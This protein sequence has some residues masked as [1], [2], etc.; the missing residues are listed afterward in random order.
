M[1]ERYSIDPFGA[2]SNLDDR[3]YP[4]PNCALP[5]TDLTASLHRRSRPCD[6]LNS[7]QDWFTEGQIPV[8]RAIKGLDSVRLVATWSSRTR[9]FIKVPY[10]DDIAVWD[11]LIHAILSNRGSTQAT[12]GAV[13]RAQQSAADHGRP[14]PAPED[15]SLTVPIDCSGQTHRVT[16]SLGGSVTCHDHDHMDSD[17]LVAAVTGTAIPCAWITGDLPAPGPGADYRTRLAYEETK[18]QYGLRALG[19]DLDAHRRWRALDADPATIDWWMNASASP[20]DADAWT[21][22]GYTPWEA[23][24]A[25]LHQQYPA[26]SGWTSFNGTAEEWR[27]AGIDVVSAHTWGGW[28]GLATRSLVDERL[29]GGMRAAAAPGFTPGAAREL[30]SRGVTYRAAVAA[31]TRW[32]EETLPPASRRI[33]VPLSLADVDRLPLDGLYA[34]S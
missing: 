12:I 22:A 21:A 11:I 3:W 32:R 26:Q 2:W 23:H 19:R 29:P 4:C 13:R 15:W 24:I 17:A 25:V 33:D 34:K 5:L 30:L 20:A 1:S 7:T 27:E 10:R 31:L 8:N 14:A 16:I 9:K 18:K 28:T 6:A